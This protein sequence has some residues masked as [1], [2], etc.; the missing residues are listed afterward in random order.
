MVMKKLFRPGLSD[1]DRVTPT[2]SELADHFPA[3]RRYARRLTNNPVDADDLVQECV[4]RALA[5]I[6]QFEPGTNLKGWLTTILTHI[7]IEGARRT[8]RY[9]E[10]LKAYALEHKTASD[11]NQ[12][13]RLEFL[14]VDKALNDLPA[15]QRAAL[16]M[17]AIDRVSYSETAQKAGVP[18]GTIR[19]RVSRA[20]Q[21][22][23]SSSYGN[24]CSRRAEPSPARS[25]SSVQ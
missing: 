14:A 1:M 11:P 23:A 16:I 8:A 9:R 3:L 10:L 18:L 2:V 7:F 15:D 5:R 20:R 4:V 25:S 17:V 22:L 19:S 6:E 13:S 24:I 12:L 21:A